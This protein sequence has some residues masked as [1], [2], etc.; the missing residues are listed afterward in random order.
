MKKSIALLLFGVILP[1]QSLWGQHYSIEELTQGFY[2]QYVEKS[3]VGQ[4]EMEGMDMLMYA[5]EEF[6][7]IKQSSDKPFLCFNE[8][9]HKAGDINLPPSVFVELFEIPNSESRLY[10]Y[11]TRDSSNRAE[12]VK[13]RDVLL[14]TY[15]GK[16]LPGGAVLVPA[17]WFSGE[18][19]ALHK[20]FLYG[21]V[22]V[23]RYLCL[24]RIKKRHFHGE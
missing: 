6:G 4:M 12:T 21:N 19:H 9:L 15:G 24:Y 11:S 16:Q 3:S 22:P 17:R 1:L 7:N 2:A 8:E 14:R 20:P 5:N 10:W 23:S 18:L 13:L